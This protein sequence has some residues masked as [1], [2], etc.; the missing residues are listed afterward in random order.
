M[1]T[2]EIFCRNF[3]AVVNEKFPDK[4]QKELAEMIGRDASIINKW[5]H[6]V[7]MPKDIGTV[8]DRLGVTIERL[9]R[10]PDRNYTPQKEESPGGVEKPTADEYGA[11]NAVITSIK[12]DRSNGLTQWLSL[13]GDGWDARIGGY[14]LSGVA[15]GRWMEALLEVLELWFVEEK[16]LVGRNVRVI[17]GTN[18]RVMAIG[19]I[20]KDLWFWPDDKFVRL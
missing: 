2:K 4:S 9:M 5:L 3:R 19:H 11:K 18:G 7:S 13:A 8:A 14:N 12:W 6:G 10:A 1:T 16:S 20:I 15:C 17:T